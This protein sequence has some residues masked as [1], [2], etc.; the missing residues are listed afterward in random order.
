MCFILIVKNR[1]IVIKN[2]FSEYK[3]HKLLKNDV[4]Y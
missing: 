4:T 3:N 2:N 1:S